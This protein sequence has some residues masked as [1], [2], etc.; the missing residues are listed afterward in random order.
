M[1]VIAAIFAD[2][3]ESFLGG[4]SVLEVRV[5][6]HSIL[7]H[8][9][10]RAAG[11]SEVSNRCLYVRPR[12]RLR[13]EAAVRGLALESRIEVLPLDSGARPRRG[14]IRSARKWNLDGWRG[15]PLGTTWFDEFVEPLEVAR[16]LD[17]Y[18]A[19]AVLCLD[20]CQPLLDVPIAQQMLAHL[21]E[22]RGEACFVFT[23]APPGLAGIILTREAVRELLSEQKPVGLLV[24]YRPE[25]PRV[26]PVA[27][28]ECVRLPAEVAQTAARFC[29]DTRRSRERIGR[30]LRETGPDTDALAACRWVRDHETYTDPGPLPVE[31]ELELTTD[32]PLPESRLRPRGHRVPRRQLEDIEA[33]GRLAAEIAAYDDARI[34]LAG[35]GD[36]LRHPRFGEVCGRIRSAG[37]CGLAVVTPLTDLSDAQAEAFFEHRVDVVEV[38][39]DANR[40]STYRSLHGADRF[41]DV[42]RHIARIQQARVDRQCP[43]PIVIAS[44]TRC[45]ETLAEVEAF[46]E[47]WICTTGWAV[48]EGY[49]E[50]C[51]MLPADGLLPLRPPVRE[52]C[53]R[54]ARRLIL[55][56]D[57]RVPICGQDVVGQTEVGNWHTHGVAEIWSGPRLRRLRGDHAGS[58]WNEHPLCAVCGEWFRP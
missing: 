41:P 21:R 3:Q 1:R 12:D 20:A 17:H 40:A 33:V 50:Y 43:Q 23:Q 55:L 39:L 5:D 8:T 52:P 58:K 27:R 24:S 49:N 53:R 26:D 29:G 57:G 37:V 14:L 16:L 51:G 32:D 48:I 31:I 15:S 46:F 25:W 34:V 35:H 4:P 47:R 22:M 38:L 2:F 54:L 45:S 56:A 19:D 7:E 9:L 44:I 28:A 11:L 30:I 18:A 42:L 6:R 13:A 10:R 36:P